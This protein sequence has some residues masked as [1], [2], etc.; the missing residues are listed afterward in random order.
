MRPET[1]RHLIESYSWGPLGAVP[2][3][4]IQDRSDKTIGNVQRK[5]EVF[6]PLMTAIGADMAIQPNALDYAQH[7]YAMQDLRMELHKRYGVGETHSEEVYEQ[8]ADRGKRGG[9]I[10]RADVVT[11]R[12]MRDKGVPDHVIQY[13]VNGMRYNKARQEANK[14][15]TELSKK[16]YEL[17][18]QGKDDPVMRMA[19]QSAWDELED[20]TY[21][22]VK[23]NNR[24]YFEIMQQQ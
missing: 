1:M 20:L 8:Y 15:F 3:S 13:V 11:E 18:Q 17:R 5:G 23:E 16:Y 4:V 12:A 24:A 19:V 21:N 6:G 14:N 2:K 22:F 9:V 7:T 10:K